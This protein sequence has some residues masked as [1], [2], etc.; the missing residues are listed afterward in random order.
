MCPTRLYIA[1]EHASV[2]SAL[3]ERLERDAS[4]TVIGQSGNAEEMLREIR[5]DK[6]DVVLVEVKRSDGMGLEIIRQISN[7]PEPPY[8]IVLTSYPSEWEEEAANRAGAT[9]YLLKNI[10]TGDLI[11]HIAQLLDR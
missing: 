10:A 2:R 1:D 8:L 7:L 11:H 4:L 6:P 9:A 3:A 5:Q